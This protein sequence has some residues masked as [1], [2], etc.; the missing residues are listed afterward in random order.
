M[1]LL[2]YRHLLQLLPSSSHTV[3][4]SA[5]QL[6]GVTELWKNSNW[7]EKKICKL[8]NPWS[9]KLQELSQLHMKLCLKLKVLKQRRLN[10]ALW[11]L[12]LLFVYFGGRGGALQI[13]GGSRPSDSTNAIVTSRALFSFLF[14]ILWL[15]KKVILAKKKKKKK[16]WRTIEK[17]C[18][19]TEVWGRKGP[20]LRLEWETES[21]EGNQRFIF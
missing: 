15:Q 4:N 10:S 16:S 1:S 7:E 11:S 12:L 14:C 19:R 8:W 9:K 13:F 21:R 6:K 18:I 17:H 2:S 20:E 5:M 3:R